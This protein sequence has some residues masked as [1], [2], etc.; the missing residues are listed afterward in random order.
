MPHSSSL[1]GSCTSGSITSSGSVTCASRP[2]PSITLV[3]GYTLSA[4]GRTNKSGDRHSEVVQ[5]REGL[6]LHHPGRWRFGRIRPSHGDR[7]HRVQESRRG[8]A[9]AV[10]D[11]P[12]AKG[13]PGERGPSCLGTAGPSPHEVAARVDRIIVRRARARRAAAI[14]TSSRCGD[15]DS[16]SPPSRRGRVCSAPGTRLSRSIALWRQPPI[17]SVPS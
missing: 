14:R 15:K 16:P 8:P 10:R 3:L 13:A 4:R 2:R 7:G 17:R 1:A 6:R 9:R 5:R 12:G 11:H